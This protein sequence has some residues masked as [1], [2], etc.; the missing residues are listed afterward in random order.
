MKPIRY[1]AHAIE[2]MHER[3]LTRADTESVI[4]DPAI[5]LPPRRYGRH[6][7]IGYVRGRAIRIA[8]AESAEALWVITVMLVEA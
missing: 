7:V 8:Y 3:G 5:I 1:A 6:D 4:R 2:R